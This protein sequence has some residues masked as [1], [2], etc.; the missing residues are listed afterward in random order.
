[1]VRSDMHERF[2]LRVMWFVSENIPYQKQKRNQFSQMARSDCHANGTQ[3]WNCSIM[4]HVQ[5][6][7]SF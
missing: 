6:I 2:N 7:I 1:M 3:F 5:D 4:T